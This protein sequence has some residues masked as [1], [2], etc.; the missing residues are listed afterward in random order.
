MAI[1]GAFA[2]LEQTIIPGD[3]SPCAT[4]LRSNQ[5]QLY[6]HPERYFPYLH[7]PQLQI[8]EELLIPLQ[9]N[10][11][12]LGMLWIVSHDEA[13]RFDSEDQ[14]LMMSLGGFTASALQSMQQL[15]QKAEDAQREQA[16]AAAALRESQELNQQILDSSDDCIKV[17]DLEGRL[18]FMSPGGKRCGCVAN[19]F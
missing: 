1:A 2:D 3:F 5:P 16:R 19:T 4:T 8:V 15:R 10:R 6:A 11:Q 17:L 13:R 7:H 12:P 14:R 18:L 9:V